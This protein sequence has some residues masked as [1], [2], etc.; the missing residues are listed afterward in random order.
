[1]RGALFLLGLLCPAGSCA[2]YYEE[3]DCLIKIDVK[4]KY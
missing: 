2:A 1:M 3:R 4:N